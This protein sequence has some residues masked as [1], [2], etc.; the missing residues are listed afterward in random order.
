MSKRCMVTVVMLAASIGAADAW[1]S[2]EHSEIGDAAFQTAIATLDRAA[3]GTSATLLNAPHLSTGSTGSL[4]V[5]ISAVANGKEVTN[6]RNEVERFSFGDLVAIY[7]DY[8]EE[9]KDV[10]VS[11]F[12][13]R[14]A[15]LKRI[16]RGGSVSDFPAEFEI[17]MNLAVNNPNHFS[18]RA[19]QA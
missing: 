6:G 15:T 4:G 18:L 11:T 16:A 8:A 5:S 2:F 13:K 7:G 19:A 10:N 14:A 17:M 3:P 12:G 1:D 9:F